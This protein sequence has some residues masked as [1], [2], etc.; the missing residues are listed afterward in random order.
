[1]PR[2]L[3][4]KPPSMAVKVTNCSRPSQLLPV[5][6][7]QVVRVRGE[8]MALGDDA[9]YQFM[10]GTRLSAL[11]NPW[12]SITVGAV[13]PGSVVVRSAPKGPRFR[14]DEDYLLDERWA[15]LGRI[16]T[17]RIAKG[18]TVYVDYAYYLSRLD[19]LQ[20]SAD[21]A[22]DIRRGKGAVVCPQPAGA[23]RGQRALANIWVQPGMTAVTRADIYPIG[24]AARFSAPDRAGTAATRKL[25]ETGGKITIVALGDSVTVGHEASKPELAF[26]ALFASTLQE[27]YPQAQIR[28]INAGIAGSTSAYALERLERDV[29]AHHPQLVIIEFVNDMSL[30]PHKIRDNYRELISRL[31]RAGAE[32]IV[33]TPHY[34]WPEWMGNFESALGALRRVAAEQG[35]GLADASARWAALRR[36][37]LPYQTL[38][39]NC[40]NHPDDRGHRMF[41]EVLVELF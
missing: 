16:A 21:G 12:G 36:V 3:P 28:L 13:V 41:V 15:A 11:R 17:G 31:R 30:P 14:V 23:G 25:L 6:R 5:R 4:T 35:A 39:V 19:T 18:A 38:L 24:R 32:V 10:A 29:L 2:V 7:P 37:G 9:P 27:R 34:T 22:A 8:A 20:V 26:P 1:M 40:I 33:I